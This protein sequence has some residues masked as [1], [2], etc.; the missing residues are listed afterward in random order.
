M[1][2]LEKERTDKKLSKNRLALDSHVD[3]SYISYAE[4]RGF[5]LYDRQLERLAESLGYTGDPHEL[6]EEVNER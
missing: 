1:I 3:I 6:L 5:R 2:R 4:K